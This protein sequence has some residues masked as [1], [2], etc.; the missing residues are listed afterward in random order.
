YRRGEGRS[1]GP[2]WSGQREA[3]Q[4]YLGDWP[5]FLYRPR[6]G[7]T[8]QWNDRLCRPEQRSRRERFGRGQCRAAE[9]LPRNRLGP[10]PGA[11]P[12]P[13]V[14]VDKPG[15]PEQGAGIHDPQFD[16]PGRGWTADAERLH[17]HRSPTAADT[18]A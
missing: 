2:G 16:L 6:S 1:L 18:K 14:G 17:I 7:P 12:L 4:D 8:G 13:A 10:D 9:T 15:A 5:R 3:P 11:V